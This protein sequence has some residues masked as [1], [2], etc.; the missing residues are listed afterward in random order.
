YSILY[1]LESSGLY[2]FFL[3]FL[4]IFVVLFAIL[5]KTYIFGGGSSDG[6]KTNINVVVSLIIAAL[7]VVQTDL[8]MFMNMYLSRMAFFIV[9]GI[10]FMLVVAMFAGTKGNSK[11]EGFGIGAGVILAIVAL[12]WSLSSSTYGASFPYWFYLSES[13]ISAL[14]LVGVLVLVIALV[15]AG[16]NK[17]NKGITLK[18]LRG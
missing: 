5:E 11:F 2:E 14:L 17:D 7:L 10:M 8:V 13:V 4:L 9:A 18:G 16:N 1:T 3:P 12:L 6:P 15:A